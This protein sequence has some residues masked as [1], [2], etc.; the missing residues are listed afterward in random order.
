MDHEW[1]KTTVQELYIVF[2]FTKTQ[3]KQLRK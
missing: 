2:V 3:Q 1:V